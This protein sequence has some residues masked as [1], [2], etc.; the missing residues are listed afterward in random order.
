L[1][2]PSCASSAALPGSSRLAQLHKAR[3]RSRVSVEAMRELVEAKVRE[4]RRLVV[5]GF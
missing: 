3:E 4:C 5:E 1:L 2:C